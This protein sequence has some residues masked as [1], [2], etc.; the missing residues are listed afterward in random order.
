MFKKSATG[1]VAL[2]YLSGDVQAIKSRFRPIAGSVPWHKAITDTTWNTPDWP[3][4]YFVPD[5]GVDTD[6]INV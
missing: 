1:L 2:T 3:V 5:F 4:N 6:V